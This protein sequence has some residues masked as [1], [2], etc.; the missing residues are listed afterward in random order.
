[1]NHKVREW[2]SMKV[3]EKHLHKWIG[4]LQ[5]HA[6]AWWY[7]PLIAILAG[8][9]H[10]IVIIPTD[11]LLVSGVL[12]NP[13]RWVITF[14]CIAV[15]SSVGAV[16]LA[17]AVKVYGLPF[18]LAIAPSMVETSSWQWTERFMTEYGSLALFGVAASPLIQQPAIIL[19]ALSP[20]PLSKIFLVFLLGRLVKFL[21][22]GWVASHTPHLV[23]RLWGVR[24]EVEEV[25]E[26]THQEIPE[27][28]VSPDEK[29][30]SKTV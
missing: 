18:I 21:V 6:Q 10:F 11:G 17:W 3:L 19:A 22:L 8:L 16:A 25:V 27:K 12:L 13:R 7:A 15:G 20:A 26:V 5:R 9:D 29:P 1:M 14:L 24:R 4:E 2:I 23:R 28:P 30:H